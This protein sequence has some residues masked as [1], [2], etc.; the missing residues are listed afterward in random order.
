MLK[1][2]FQNFGHLMR[3]TDSLEKTLARG[4]AR[5]SAEGLIWWRSVLADTARRELWRKEIIA[6]PICWLQRLQVWK[7]SCKDGEK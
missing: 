1:L 5:E 6:A 3:R 4:A 7:S 2:K